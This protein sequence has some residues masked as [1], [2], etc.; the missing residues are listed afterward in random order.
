MNPSV[1]AGR[2]VGYHSHPASFKVPKFSL[3]PHNAKLKNGK[4]SINLI[5][6]I[7]GFN[8]SEGLSQNSVMLTTKVFDATN[9][10]EIFKISGGE[11]CELEVVQKFKVGED[12]TEIEKKIVLELYLAEVINY[13]RP[14][15]GSSSYELVFI[16]KQG[17]MNQFITI[18]RGFNGTL[19][20]EVKGILSNDFK[21]QDLNTDNWVDGTGAPK[22]GI[23]PKL[24]PFD[25][26]Q[27]LVRT[28]YDDKSPIFFAESIRDGYILK[29]L[30]QMYKQ[31]TYDM[32]H[33]IPYLTTTAEPGKHQYNNERQVILDYSIRSYAD[34]INRGNKGAFGSE[35]L[36][37]D[38]S[39]KKKEIKQYSDKQ[40]RTLPNKHKSSITGAY[41][42]L[43]D[44]G[45]GVDENHA[46]QQRVNRNYQAEFFF[47]NKNTKAYGE[48]TSNYHG[49]VTSNVGTSFSY[50]SNMHST[51]ANVVLNGDPSLGIGDMIYLVL[52]NETAEA[53]TDLTEKDENALF[54]GAYLVTNII[55]NFND[56]GYTMTVSISKCDSATDLDKEVD[57]SKGD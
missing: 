6:L 30:D 47:V 15:I 12:Q 26:I 3:F 50:L 57:L 14:N 19:V 27:W 38:I 8:I 40:V 51:R 49:D 7:Q 37:I 24:K 20:D 29:G 53:G 32:Y 4:R 42:G 5:N 45:N 1:N 10:L 13:T 25:A 21:I 34:I 23:Y 36:S 55:H 35:T 43:K 2:D 46:G 44:F 48:D 33:N 28:S 11:K 31:A 39:E 16:T 17:F 22:K 54:S 41:T 9:M 52:A 18:N 56:L